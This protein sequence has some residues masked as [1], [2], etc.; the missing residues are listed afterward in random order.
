[1]A[2]PKFCSKYKVYS[3]TDFDLS[4]GHG[5]SPIGVPLVL[6]QTFYLQRILTFEIILRVKC[7][8]VTVITFLGHGD[9]IGHV[10]ILSMVCGFP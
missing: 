10:T 3:F 1:M 4:I 9:V 5:P 7:I 2:G 6:T 8:W